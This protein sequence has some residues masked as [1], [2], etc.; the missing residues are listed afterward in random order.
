MLFLVAGTRLGAINGPNCIPMDPPEHT[1][2]GDFDGC[3]G[4]T[5]CTPGNDIMGNYMPQS[6]ARVVALL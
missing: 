4:C 5:N 6:S 3:T 1:A 2:W